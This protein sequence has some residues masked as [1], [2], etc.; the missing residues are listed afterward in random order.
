[1]KKPTE[2]FEEALAYIAG[3]LPDLGI[4]LS[5]EQ[6]HLL[7]TFLQEL[8]AVNEHTNLVSCADPLIVARE[9]VLDSLT[10]VP[11]ISDGVQAS[12]PTAIVDLGSGAGFPAIVL[13]VALPGCQFSL[14]E[15]IG[16]KARFLEQLI[17]KM[18]LAERVDVHN[19]RA[20]ELAHNPRF[21]EQ[22][23]FATARAVGKLD[24]ICELALPFLRV[25][26]CML[27]QKSAA[28]LPEE[29]ERGERALPSLG[30]Q[31]KEVI[32]ANHEV[33][34]KEHFVMVVE[35]VRQTPRS[36][37]RKAASMKREPLGAET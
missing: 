17:I 22:F 32:A 6:M 4:A 8:A 18:Q 24:H 12:E 19:E 21:R 20:E 37:P 11:I 1:L 33:L 34:G 36:Y 27:A 10:L 14:I 30:G 28:Q 3:K 16:K 13:A 29:K 7:F 25:G 9:H 31:L 35:K 26:G 23:H 2:N 5:A 15:S